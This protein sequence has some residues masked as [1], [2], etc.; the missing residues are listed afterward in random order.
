MPE[1]N[2]NGRDEDELYSSVMENVSNVGIR[3]FERM[4]VEINMK[5]VSA[6]AL[7]NVK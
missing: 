1:T 4:T 7:M 2:I 6:G 3:V 5:L